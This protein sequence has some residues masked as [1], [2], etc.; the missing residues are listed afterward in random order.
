MKCGSV[1]NMRF[2]PD[3]LK[4]ERSLQKFAALLQTYFNLGGYHVQFNI[5]SSDM[6]RDAQRNSEKYRDLL[7]RV[8]T[9]TA[10]FTELSTDVQNDI[11]RRIEIEEV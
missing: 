3:A 6:L 4:D 8:S 11:I 9:W 1:L 2:N 5:V 7:V 10:Y